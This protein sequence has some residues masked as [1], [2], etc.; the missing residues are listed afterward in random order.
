MH[1]EVLA[2]RLAAEVGVTVPETILAN[3]GGTTIAVS[4]SFGKQSLDVPMVRN[5][6][7]ADYDSDAFR[8]AL[9]DESGV[10]VFHSW[11]GTQDLKDEHVIVRPDGEGQYK[12]ASIDFAIGPFAFG[13][14]P[15]VP[16]AP[17][18]LVGNRDPA[19]IERVLNTIEALS[20]EQ[21]RGVV[22]ELPDDVL[23]SAEKDRIVKE[24]VNRKSALRPKFKAAGWLP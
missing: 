19:S 22:E 6:S 17:P 13:S 4:K 12:V 18:S 11:L 5:T 9:R 21:I 20:E 1:R 2:S 3:C 8:R 24:L 15:D 16:A 23:S 14:E 7:Q 10:L